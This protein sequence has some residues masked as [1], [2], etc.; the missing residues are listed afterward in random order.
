MKILEE[1]KASVG[2]CFQGRLSR[3]IGVLSG[4]HEAVNINISHNEQI[5][6]VIIKLKQKL[7]TIQIDYFVNIFENELKER[8]YE[9]EVIEEWKVYVVDNY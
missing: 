1:M 3:L 9:N 6:N 7:G 4:Y 2:K 8:G 5:G